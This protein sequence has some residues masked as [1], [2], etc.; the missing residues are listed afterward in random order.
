MIERIY[1]IFYEF[2]NSYTRYVHGE[3]IVTRHVPFSVDKML[4]CS[5]RDIHYFNYCYY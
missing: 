4:P 2:F 5:D 1:I 3:P